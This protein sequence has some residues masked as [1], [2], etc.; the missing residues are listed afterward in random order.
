VGPGG[1]LLLP[2]E[3]DYSRSFAGS[4]QDAW[5][6]EYLA[7]VE[8]DCWPALPADE[9]L[10]EATSAEAGLLAD[11][12][13]WFDLCDDLLNPQPAGRPPATFQRLDDDHHATT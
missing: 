5:R 9:S 12:P 1:S 2:V 8:V 13:D 3:V 7:N 6:A 10:L 11:Y 4:D